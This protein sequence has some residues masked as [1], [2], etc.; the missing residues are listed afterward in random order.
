[1]LSFVTLQTAVSRNVDNTQLVVNQH[2]VRPIE[3][4]QFGNVFRLAAKFDFP[5]KDTA[6]LFSGAVTMVSA[7]P[8]RQSGVARRT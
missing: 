7:C 2:H 8:S 3:A 4:T 5:A 1:M 6:F